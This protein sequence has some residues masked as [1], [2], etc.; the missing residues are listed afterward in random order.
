MATA[1]VVSRPT[2]RFYGCLPRQLAPL[3]GRMLN[4]DSGDL[5]QKL[6]CTEAKIRQA[7]SASREAF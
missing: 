5:N 1:F 4:Y 3:E 6:L 7:H 2:R